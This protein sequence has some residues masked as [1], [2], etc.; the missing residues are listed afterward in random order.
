VTGDE[1]GSGSVAGPR[2][3]PYEL[4]F[5]EGDFESER[6]PRVAR[7]AEEVGVDTT[8]RERFPFLTTVSELVR[9][10]AATDAPPEALDQYRALLYHAVNFWRSHREVYYLEPALARFL[11]E[12]APSLASWELKLPRPA[13]YL[14][15][16]ANLF[17]AS[18][19][20][21]AVPEPVDGFFVTAGRAPDPAGTPYTRLEVLMVL[22]VR[23]DRDG[24]SVMGFDTAVGQGIAQVWSEAAGREQ[25]RDFSSVLPGGE[26]A[27]LCSITT[28]AEVLKLVARAFWYIDS[29]PSAFRLDDPLERRAEDRAGSPRSRL[30]VTRVG[31]EP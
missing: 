24:F 1:R 20:A 6:F 31:L 15:L 12:S 9:E 7:E 5:G 8:L 22:G 27:G 13:V 4:V 2:R 11:V 29:H 19:A 23:R 14:Q 26:E 28:S 10:L 30:A 17:W 21:D 18:V 25:G 3:T 16:P